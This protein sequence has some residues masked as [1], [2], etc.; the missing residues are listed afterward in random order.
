VGAGEIFQ[1]AKELYYTTQKPDYKCK[2]I[3][4]IWMFIVSQT[5]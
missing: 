5:A 2:Y 1:V 4:R 3:L